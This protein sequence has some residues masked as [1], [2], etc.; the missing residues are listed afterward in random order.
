MKV[1][2]WAICEACGYRKRAKAPKE[3]LFCP[4][5][6]IS[7]KVLPK[8]YIGWHE[9][10]KW[11]E[12][13]IGEKKRTA[14]AA[15]AKIEVNKAEG[16]S[17]LDRLRK[18]PWDEAEKIFRAWFET[19]RN[20]R[21]QAMFNTCLKRFKYKF[22][23]MYFQDITPD[24]IEVHKA[25][26]LAEG[27]AASTIN[28]DIMTIKRMANYLAQAKVIE[29][30]QFQYVEKL[31]E[32]DALEVYYTPEQIKKIY[33]EAKSDKCHN[34]ALPVIIALALNTGMRKQNVLET[35]ITDL[36]FQREEIRITLVKKNTQRRLT[37]PMTPELKT[38]LQEYLA[39]RKVRDING[40]LFPSPRKPGHPMRS[41]ANFGFENALVR[42]KI[43]KGR[44]ECF[45]TLRHT[46]ATHF[47][48]Q[49]VEG[50]GMNVDGALKILQEILG[51]SDLKTTM[52]YAHVVERHKKELMSA[53]SILGGNENG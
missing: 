32:P 36:N 46:F 21:T 11:H 38:T 26:R 28:K 30:N 3:G 24:M 35:K 9:A 2:Q 48:A 33:Q 20:D 47:L 51:H 5:C 15:L 16:R 14:D 43:K 4:K 1:F 39:K 49:M 34:P 6:G 53:F 22:G 23:E 42:A 45:H 29:A 52:R 50:R 37:I 41:D 27:K 44:E 8:K 12:K 40:W 18:I 31:K 10:G 13:A 19:N 25:E 7:M 17:N